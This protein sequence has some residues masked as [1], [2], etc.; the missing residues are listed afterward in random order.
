MGLT[1]YEDT[2]SGLLA[3]DI[4][5]ID[6]VSGPTC[7]C[8]WIECELIDGH[9]WVW[10]KGY[11]P[12]SFVLPVDRKERGMRQVLNEDAEGLPFSHANGVDM[13]IDQTIGRTTYTA[14]MFREQHLYDVHVRRARIAA[15]LGD[16]YESFNEYLK[17][18][19]YEAL[20][21]RDRLAAA[22]TCLW[23]FQSLGGTTMESDPLRKW[24]E[25]ELLRRWTEVTE[26]G[27]GELDPK[28]WMIRADVES[29]LGL[30]QETK[31]SRLRA[32]DLQH[33]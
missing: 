30:E 28:W 5:V 20:A 15:D 1:F 6:Q 24:L 21:P 26:L 10:L 32:L 17:A 12:E 33:R 19:R 27:P 29:A 31:K 7:F 8:E 18:E 16:G 25:V 14:R 13:S 22:K 11:R 23:V 3:V 9:R 4:V 2:M